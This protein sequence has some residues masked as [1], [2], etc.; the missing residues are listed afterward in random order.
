M[1]RGLFQDCLEVSG[2]HS[3]TRLLTWTG[4]RGV[5]ESSWVQRRTGRDQSSIT[6]TSKTD[7]TGENEF[8]LLPIR[9]E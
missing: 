9:S 6:L 8:N 2:S 7:L 5:T 4:E 1:Q 3:V